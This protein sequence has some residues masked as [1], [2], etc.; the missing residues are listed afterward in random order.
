M[1]AGTEEQPAP[2]PGVKKCHISNTPDYILIGGSIGHGES[3]GGSPPNARFVACARFYIH[4]FTTY[5]S[6]GHRGGVLYPVG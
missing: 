4:M 6:V 3:S 1:S 5:V 2:Y